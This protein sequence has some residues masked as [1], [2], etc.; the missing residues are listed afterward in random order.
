[1]SCKSSFRPMREHKLVAVPDRMINSFSL[2][3]Y[4][5][6][7]TLSQNY[8]NILLLLLR[9]RQACDH[10]QLVKRYNSDSVGKVSEE[11][12]KKLPKEDLVSLLSRLE[13]SPICCV[14][15]VSA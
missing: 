3:A 5:D 10:P 8:A 2:Q 4:A 13:S 1:M 14:C 6:A 11:A 15:H 9:L 12:V 7:G